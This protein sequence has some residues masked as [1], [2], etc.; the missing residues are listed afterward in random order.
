[1]FAYLLP[2]PVGRAVVHDVDAVRELGHR[3][4]D[5]ADE[6]LLVVRRDHDADRVPVIHRSTSLRR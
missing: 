1:V 2:R 6:P 3:V 4:D 5:L